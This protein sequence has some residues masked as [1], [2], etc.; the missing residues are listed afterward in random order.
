MKHF[1][2][3]VRA[4]A[5]CAIGLAGGA[6]QAGGL[7]LYEV[8]T[9]DVGLASAG[10]TARAQDAATVFTNPAGM[11]R[12]DGDQVTLGLQALY[13]R[14][15]FSVDPAGTS[16]RLGTDGGG[17]AIGWFPGGG[18]FYSHSISPDLKVGMALT[19]NFGLSIQYNDTWAGRYRTQESTLLGISFVPAVAYRVNEKFSVGASVNAMRGSFKAKVGVNNIVG[20]DGQLE[21][22]DTVWG[23]GGNLGLLYEVDPGTRFGLTYNSQVKLDFS[24]RPKWS[25]TG[26][27]LTT[28]LRASGLDNA[29][30][31][32]GI[33]VPQGANAGFYHEVSPKWALLGS[34][35]WQQWSKFGEVDIG[36]DANNPRSLTA[37]RDYKDTWHFAGGAQYRA[38][39]RVTLMGGI[40]YDS[41]FQN[42]NNIPPAIPAN[43]AWRFGFGA[44]VAESAKFNWGVSL[45]YLYAGS[46]NTNLTG[47]PV[48]AGGRGDLAGS[49]DSPA[50]IL[51]IAA[52]LNYKF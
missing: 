46:L 25:G 51:F 34:I 24:T 17:N 30:V 43:D 13:G 20:P 41:E 47:L 6:A 9:A 5:I 44:Q 39:E 49:Y 45:E 19:G 36:I 52:N 12:L 38:S 26:P 7:L 40:A 28:V 42:S 35:G 18:L 33:T 32:L 23:F 11:T 15:N 48:V 1:K 8:G 2:R 31:D 27:L 14:A 21:L 3:Q 50:G 37:N 10:Y 29:M 22:D 4:T 16:P